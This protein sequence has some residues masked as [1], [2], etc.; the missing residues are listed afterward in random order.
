MPRTIPAGEALGHRL[1]RATAKEEVIAYLAAADVPPARRR[2]WY[3]EWCGATCSKLENADLD[4]VAPAGTPK[5]KQ[6][7]LLEP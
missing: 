3:R 4:R 1:M 7:S 2:R 6:L 5:D